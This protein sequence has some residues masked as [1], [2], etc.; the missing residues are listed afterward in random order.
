MP[1]GPLNNFGS[2]SRVIKSRLEAVKIAISCRE[3]NE[4]PTFGAATSRVGAASAR[5][6]RP[7]SI[8]NISSSTIAAATYASSSATL[9]DG[10]T[11]VGSG[12]S[13]I[14]P[15]PQEDLDPQSD[16]DLWATQDD[17]PVLDDVD[18]EDPAAS[19]STAFGQ[20]QPKAVTAEPSF[21]FG[22]SSDDDPT[23]TP[24]YKEIMKVLKDKFKLDC[25]RP[26]QLEAINATLDGKDVF[27]LMPTGG[28]KSLCYQLPA[29]CKTG[30]T[31]GVTVVVSPLLA[32]MQD[33]FEGL[34]R[35][36]IDVEVLNSSTGS[37]EHSNIRAR[38]AANS[39]NKPCLLYVTPEKLAESAAIKS[40]LGRLYDCSELARFVI[41]EAHCVATWGR[42]FREAVGFSWS[43]LALNCTC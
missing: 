30:R 31:R 2:S 19:I 25:F 39:R 15:I 28:G 33:Q 23:A 17:I 27:V 43:S 29:I 26:N 10:P 14:V 16:D 3:R 13:T 20:L 9:Y 11:A 7:P 21:A 36:N 18:L 38:L 41:D 40:I 22:P 1:S 8:V 24:Y 42:E 34:R 35:R 32:L 5:D 37:D 6:M 12:Q 4:E